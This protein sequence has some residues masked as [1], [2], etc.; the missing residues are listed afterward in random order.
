MKRR[1]FVGGI[2]TALAGLLAG[3]VTGTPLSPDVSRSETK[4]YDVADG[5]RL[6]VDNRNGSVTVR[7]DDVDAV[8]V[9]VTVSGRTVAAIDGTTVAAEETD[10]VILLQT[11]FGDDVDASKVSVS[12]TVRCPDGV[13]VGRVRTTNGSVEVTDVAGDATVESSNG[14]VTAENVAGSVALGTSNGNVR[15]EGI[16]GLRGAKTENA[17]VVVDVP[18]L[19]GDTEIRTS[20]G[21]V[22]AALA[23]DLDAA[24]TVATDH[25][26][27]DVEGLDLSSAE[28]SETRVSG[29]LGD[30]THEL[31]VTTDNDDVDLTALSE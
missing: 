31:S 17:D 25:G 5:T 14:S 22:D 20:N 4:T 30:G 10:D 16:D 13:R 23:P 7:S 1:S 9:D 27:I 26:S 28:T 19:S 21:S 12:L 11:S 3:C 18:A 8:E 2:G 29:T 15:A 24:L 6:G